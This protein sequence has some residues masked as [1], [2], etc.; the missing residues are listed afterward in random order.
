MLKDLVRERLVAAAD[1]IFGLFEKTIAAYEEQLRRATEETERH[2]R[3]LEAVCPP[4]MVIPVEG[5]PGHS[6]SAPYLHSTHR[7]K[8]DA[9]LR[10]F[11]RKS[12]RIN[13][14]IFLVKNKLIRYQ[15]MTEDQRTLG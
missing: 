7:L 12:E 10:L 5:K 8:L 4:Q 2:R 1:E 9:K 15:T 11:Y 6:A 3:Q 13:C 14:R